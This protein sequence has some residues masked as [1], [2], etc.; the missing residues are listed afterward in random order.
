MQPNFGSLY[1]PDTV[2]VD[3]KTFQSLFDMSETHTIYTGNG[4][5]LLQQL[6]SRS[7]P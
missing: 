2:Q 4:Q 3:N 6:N 1:R 7:D 5:V